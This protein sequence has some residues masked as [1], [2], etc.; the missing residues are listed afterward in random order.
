MATNYEGYTM[1][2]KYEKKKGDEYIFRRA[3]WVE[4]LASNKIVRKIGEIFGHDTAKINIVEV[5][6]DEKESKNDRNK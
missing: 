1:K 2:L 5:D 3:T 4:C 6:I